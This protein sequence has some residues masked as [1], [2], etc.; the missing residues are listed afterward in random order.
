MELILKIGEYE[1]GAD[2]ETDEAIAKIDRV[3]AFL[4]QGLSE[5]PSY[6]ETLAMLAEAVA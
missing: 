2:R 6:A 4:K 5:R 1:K 3:N